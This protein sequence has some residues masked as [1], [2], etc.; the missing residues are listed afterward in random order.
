[1][2]LRCKFEVQFAPIEQGLAEEQ[3]G[4]DESNF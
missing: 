4:F 3:L 2:D 1:M